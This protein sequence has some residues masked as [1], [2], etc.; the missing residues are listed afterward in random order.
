MATLFHGTSS[1]SEAASIIG[2]W[3][4]ASSG[5][6]RGSRF[7]I[8]IN[9]ET[10]TDFGSMTNGGVFAEW[11]LGN[12]TVQAKGGWLFG[13]GTPG[14]G[15]GNYLGAGVVGYFVPNLAIAGSVSWADFGSP[16]R[17]QGRR[18]LRSDLR[19]ARPHSTPI[20][21][22][23]PSSCVSE[24]VPH[25]VYRRL[26]FTDV[27]LSENVSNPNLRTEFDFNYNTFF[28]GVPLLHG[29]PWARSSSMHRNG[30]LHK[31]LRGREVS[32]R[33]GSER[34]S[35]VPARRKV[36]RALSFSGLDE[37]RRITRPRR[38]AEQVSAPWE[39]C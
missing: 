2:I 6:A 32:H 28:I 16:A 35:D 25:L 31:F 21:R 26:Q 27:T 37:I 34:T 17:R 7:G 39:R 9:Y 18:L 33:S 10:I 36:A 3:A 30:N 5:P 8:N 4:A 23:K 13:G 19:A 15:R 24:D 38:D 11:Y 22:S 29:R 20:S 12:F 1:R 14:G